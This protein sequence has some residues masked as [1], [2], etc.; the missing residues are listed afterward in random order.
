MIEIILFFITYVVL[1]FSVIGYG[2]IMARFSKLTPTNDI[3][4][5]I[6]VILGIIFLSFVS[7]ITIFF[8]SHNIF[9]NSLIHLI[10]IFFF[11][12][13][14]N[15][16]KEFKN[17]SNIIIILSL[18]IGLI[19]SKTHDDFSFYHL[20]QS[21]NFSQN[22]FQIGL[23]NLDFSYSHHSS[24][25][26]LNSIFYLPFYKFLLFNIPNQIIFTGAI[27]AFYNFSKDTQ[28]ENFLRYYSII[29]L[30]YI[31]I[32]FTRLAEFGTDTSGQLLIL[33][34]FYFIFK[35]FLV[36]NLQQ[37]KEI[38]ILTGF[39]LIYC[40][41]LKT[42][43]ILYILVFL[44]IAFSYNILK[45]FRIFLKSFFIT[46]FSFLFLISFFLLNLFTSGCIIYPFPFLCFESLT[47][48]L[49]VS[50]VEDYQIWYEAWAK[51]LAGAGYAT[52]GYKEILG[53]FSW[54][55]IW[56]KNYFFGRFSDNIILL[57]F[58]HSIFLYIFKGRKIIKK[59]N[60]KLFLSIYSFILFIA[61]VWFFKHPALR[62][63]GYAPIFLIFSLP[64]S[65]YLSKFTFTEIKFSK[66]TNILL[67]I[68]VLFFMSKNLVRINSEILR[69]DVYKFSNFP[70]FSVPIV[71]YQKIN[72][73]DEIFVFKPLK[74]NCWSTP[75]PCPYSE[76]LSAKKKMGFIIFYKD[77]R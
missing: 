60:L 9:F 50:E 46:A 21:L 25:L 20:Q 30:I 31:I 34:F 11:F 10:G 47:W 70:F 15:K 23:S 65:F 56:Y 61:F 12:K 58:I 26:Y 57:T 59:L 6:K 62:Y 74:N 4:I 16:F 29:S 35:F 51:S 73:T 71:N 27:L 54:I 40:I 14:F 37:K 39:F 49:P 64:T 45:F 5:G 42:Y 13:N 43:F 33:L 55:N 53:S 68:A 52:E 17:L 72:L 67:I 24:L 7:Y 18:F 8:I 32:K 36:K 77:K 38:I 66:Y 48:A 76:G 75:A 44:Y 41:T 2:L 19:I 1:F 3:N 28:N 63:G 69:N 22:K